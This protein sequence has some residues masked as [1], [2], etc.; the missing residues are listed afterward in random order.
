MVDGV[1]AARVNWSTASA[2]K[3]D[4]WVGGGVSLLA[5]EC[6]AYD[7]LAFTSAY[8][9]HRLGQVIARKSIQF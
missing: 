9:F 3:I 6:D 7:V 8:S 1:C 2:M 4:L 5:P